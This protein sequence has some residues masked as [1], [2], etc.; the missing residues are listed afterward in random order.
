M[1]SHS[2]FRILGYVYGVLGALGSL[3]E[4]FKSASRVGEAGENETVRHISLPGGLLAL[5]FFI[6]FLVGIYKDNPMLVKIYRVFLIVTY[7]LG[8][9]AISIAILVFIGFAI[10]AADAY[11]GVA[12]IIIVLVIALGIVIGLF[13]LFL[14]IVNGVMA[15]I[16]AKQTPNGTAVNYQ[17]PN[18]QN[19]QPMN[20][21]YYAPV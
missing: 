9:A 7:S 5:I 6:I 18:E 16:Q 15:A 19:K 17:P 8:I 3:G 2:G 13:C 14:W 20:N 10:F 21:P 4:V 1:V 11:E 12:V